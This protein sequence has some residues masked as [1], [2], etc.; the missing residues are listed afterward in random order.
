MGASVTFRVNSE[1]RALALR[2]AASRAFGRAAR[3]REL[4]LD[5]VEHASQPELLTE[6]HI[7]VRVF[8]RPEGYNPADDNI[9]RAAARQLRAKLKEYF[10][11]EG[12]DETI[13]LDIPKGGYL[14]IFS[15]RTA[16]PALHPARSFLW[17]WISAVTLLTCLVAGLLWDRA[18]LLSE[19][20]EP[21]T[22]LGEVLSSHPGAVRFVLTDSTLPSINQVLGETPS[23]DDYA[24]RTFVRRGEELAAHDPM[25]L[26][27]W[28]TL[29]DRQITSLAD[30]SVLT[31]LLQTHTR[32]A[33][34][35]EVRHARHMR[36]RDFKSGHF[37]ITG[38]RI[39]NPWAGLFDQY[40]DFRFT[41]TGAL[42]D[43]HPAPGAPS[44]YHRNYRD[45][46]YA[47]IALVPNISGTGDVLLAAGMGFEGTEG[48]GEFL[49]D[50]DALT[51][52]RKL[53]GLRSGMPLPHFEVLLE[54]KVMGGTSRAVRVL[55]A[56]SHAPASRQT[57]GSPTP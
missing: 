6:Q 25:L 36:T 40:T 56:R 50:P 3:L 1:Q 53:L 39:S 55:I 57:P 23:A 47:R 8:G 51:Q 41:G 35:I 20:S 2:I 54:A 5:I 16:P 4:L 10:E 18:R 14:P 52:T 34:R 45:L 11:G 43:V 48:A 21:D 46:D 49:L 42:I 30:V 26:N 33:R 15:A 12:C 44:E 7:G 32:S 38:S 19:S 27:L 29:M 22:I 24:N 31:R 9:V 37:V 13:F 17:G 28:N